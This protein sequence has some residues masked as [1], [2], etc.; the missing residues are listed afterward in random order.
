L[1]H[2]GDKFRHAA[3]GSRIEQFQ[4]S[5]L[6]PAT[7]SDSGYRIDAGQGIEAGKGENDRAGKG[8]NGS[9]DAF[10]WFRVANPTEPECTARE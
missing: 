2:G 4:K 8:F 9:R 3:C 10:Q 6:I 5:R 7:G 1:R